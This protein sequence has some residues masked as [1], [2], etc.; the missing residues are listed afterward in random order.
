MS[1]LSKGRILVIDDEPQIGWIFSKILGDAGYEVI[2]SR[3]GEDGLN[4]VQKFKPDLVFLDQKLPGKEGI[5]ILKD[6]KKI[7]PDIIVIM[8]TAYETIQTAVAAMKYGAYDYVPKPIPNERLKIIVDKVLETQSLSKQVKLLTEGNQACSSIIGQSQPMRDFLKLVRNV[9]SHDISVIFRGESGT[10]KELAARALHSLSKRKNKPFVP[11]D[12]ATLP[13]TLVESELFGYDKGAFTGAD[14]L[15]I[16]KFE[17]AHGGT[18]FLDEIGNLTTHI[19][20]KLLRVLQE[21]S[22]ERLGGQKTIN[23]DVRIISATNIDLEEAVKKGAFREDLYHR[24]HVFEIVIPPLRQRQ[25]DIILL[26][27]YFLDRFTRELGKNIRGFSQE[28]F[29][30]FREYHWPGNVRELENIVKSAVI[31][32][33]DIILPAHLSFHIHRN[34]K[35]NI[36]KDSQAIRKVSGHREDFE[37]MSL[38]AAKKVLVEEVEEYLIKKVLEETNWN[39]RKTAQILEIDYKSLFTKIKK[40]GIK[41]EPCD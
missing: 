20:V 11:V 41:R 5:H 33:K 39:K 7:S 32:A 17:Q 38:K 6:I 21:K 24:L 16:G 8:I 4:K 18:I 1:D 34:M 28:V 15:K 10:G 25:D 36:G 26:A 19:Q 23:I 9:A 35:S 29:E 37:N 12:C 3:S 14:T 13:E 30:I 2:S 40:M 22:I 31:L 27:Q